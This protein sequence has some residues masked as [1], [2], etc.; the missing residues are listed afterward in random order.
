MRAAAAAESEMSGSQ[1]KRFAG[2][3]RVTVAVTL[4]SYGL[5]LTVCIV[6]EGEWF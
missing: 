6:A 5:K 2:E 3:D 4:P 1:F